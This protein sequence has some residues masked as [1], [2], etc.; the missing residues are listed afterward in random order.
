MLAQLK[1]AFEAGE[2]QAPNLE[3]INLDDEKAVLAA[4]EKVKEGAKAKQVLVNKNRF[5]D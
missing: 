5:Q 2:L 3:E 1:S 4:Y